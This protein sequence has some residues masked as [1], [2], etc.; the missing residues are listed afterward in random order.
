[1]EL[2][3]LDWCFHFLF[4]LPQVS[5]TFAASLVT[6]PA[7]GTYLASI[8]DLGTVVTIATIVFITD[9]IFILLFVPESLAKNKDGNSPA[10]NSST[11]FGKT[12][13][14]AVSRV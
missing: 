10:V 12:D 8:Y 14:Y 11:Q 5:A 4:S 7:I 3:I 9:F 6:S 2:D 13:F 1:M